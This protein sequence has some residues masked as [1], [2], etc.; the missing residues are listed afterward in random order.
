[1]TTVKAKFQLQEIRQYMSYGNV[2][3]QNKTLIFRPVYDERIP[4]D[5]RFQK[6]TPS[7]QFE[8]QV[9]GP[10]LE[11]FKLGKYYY[12]DASEVNPEGEQ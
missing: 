7:G 3:N 4:E 9:N 12:F 11:F 10:A 6:F 2:I 8:M 5:I 1:M